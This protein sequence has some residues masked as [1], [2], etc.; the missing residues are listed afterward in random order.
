MELLVF[1]ATKLCP[2]TATFL[3]SNEAVVGGKSIGAEVAAPRLGNSV[4]RD[5]GMNTNLPGFKAKQKIHFLG[6]FLLSLL[7]MI[8]K[9]GRGE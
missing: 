4:P 2:D 6:F 1:F 8:V 5:T 3:R 7:Q 9:K